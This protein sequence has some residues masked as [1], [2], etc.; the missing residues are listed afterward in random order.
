[1][2]KCDQKEGSK[3]VKFDS[4]PSFRLREKYLKNCTERDFG[5]VKVK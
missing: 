4:Q 5:R 1:M 2:Q 3:M